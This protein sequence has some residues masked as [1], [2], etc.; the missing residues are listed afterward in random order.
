MEPYSQASY[1]ALLESHVVSPNPPSVLGPIIITTLVMFEGQ[2]AMNQK[3]RAAHSQ[4]QLKSTLTSA[5][6]NYENVP[7]PNPKMYLALILKCT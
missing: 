7:S 2:D 4:D 3:Q 6:I 5:L 1:S